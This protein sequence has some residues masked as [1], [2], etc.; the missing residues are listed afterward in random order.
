MQENKFNFYE[1]LKQ[2]LHLVYN[3]FGLKI[4]I[5]NDLRSMLIDFLTIQRKLIIPKKREVLYNPVFKNNLLTHPKKKEIQYLEELFSNG[6]NVNFFQSKKL[7]QTKF[8]YIVI[9]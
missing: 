2:E 5:Q 3:P 4:P 7:F 1:D 6:K 9:S 8:T